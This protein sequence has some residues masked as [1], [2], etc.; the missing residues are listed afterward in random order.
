MTVITAVLD[1]KTISQSLWS[2]CCRSV[3]RIDRLGM[4][5]MV[6]ALIFAVPLLIILSY[7][8]VGVSDTW[9]HLV[10]TVLPT[11]IKSSFILLIG[12]GFGVLL[13]GIPAAWLTSVCEFPGRRIFNWALLLPLA[14]PGYIIAY[15]YTGLLDYYGPVQSLIRELTGLGHREY[16]FPRIRS[17]GGAIMMLTL[18]LY[19]YVYLLAR[20]AFIEQSVC[21]L[22]ASRSLGKTPWQSFWRVALPLARPAI[23]TGLALALMETLADYGTVEYFGVSTF[24]T[25]IFRSWA[26]M[27]DEV[28]TAQLASVLLSFVI[29]LVLIERYS[30]RKSRFHHTSSRYSAIQRYPLVGWKRIAAVV[31]C[32]LPIMFGFILPVSVLLY[33]SLTL[34]E[35]LN[36]DF[37]KLVWNTLML[38]AIAAVCVVFFGLIASYA[39]RY[40]K[41]LLVKSAVGLT[42]MGYALPGLVIAIGVLIPL[43]W[44]D[45]RIIGIT[46]ALFDHSFG[47]ILS[48][49][50]IALLYA[51]MVRF[52]SV[53]INTLSSGLTKIKPSMDEAARSMGKTPSQVLRQVHFPMMKSTVLTAYL[54]VFVDVLKE[55]PATIVLRPLN[56]NTLAVRAHEMASDE[57]LIDAGPPALMIVLVGLL[58]VILLSRGI[59]RGRAGQSAS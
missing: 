45:H 43:A 23:V 32:V 18:V 46:R 50:I 6:A 5:A 1:K 47:L 48:G 53:S 21:V 24:T 51:Y 58:P 11:Y 42:S 13:L 59:A 33:W 39:Q 17:L 25:G 40:S 20:A 16:W 37:I 12:V 2:R 56:F 4:I 14:I 29:V 26:S 30:R 8:L 57:R 28:A 44:L 54:L 19:P 41:S 34:A 55:L 27:G 10:Q 38:G 36:A 3:S 31:A 9:T 15:T 22:E 7:S 35:P 52:L 49:S